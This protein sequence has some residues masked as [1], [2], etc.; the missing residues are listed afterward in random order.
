MTKSSP[1]D[2]LE[3]VTIKTTP[4]CNRA[5]SSISHQDFSDGQTLTDGSGIIRCIECDKPYSVKFE[6]SLI[7]SITTIQDAIA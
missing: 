5:I 4:C 3:T 1:I 2:Y 6:D 7:T